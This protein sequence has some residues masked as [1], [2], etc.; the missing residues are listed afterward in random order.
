VVEL[1][2][3]VVVLR[4]LGVI[5]LELSLVVAIGLESAEEVLDWKQEGLQVATPPPQEM[6]GKQMVLFA[7]LLVD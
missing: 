4:Q 1:A 6:V 7:G 2:P 5:K 3:Q